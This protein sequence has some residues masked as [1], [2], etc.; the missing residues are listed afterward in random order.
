M[1][2][3]IAIEFNHRPMGMIW[4]NEYTKLVQIN[5]HY[6][7]AMIEPDDLLT[8]EESDLF[9]FAMEKLFLWIKEK[10]LPIKFDKNEQDFVI[11]SME[12]GTSFEIWTFS[13]WKYVSLLFNKQTQL[14]HLEFAI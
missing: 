5:L 13:F 2:K 6:G 10:K 3:Y 8:E 11:S 12:D 4:F 1:N 14:K 9:D 7:I